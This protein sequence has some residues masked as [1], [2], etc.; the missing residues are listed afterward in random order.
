MEEVQAAVSP[1]SLRHIESIGGARYE[2]TANYV[3]EITFLEL[4]K[5]MLKRDLERERPEP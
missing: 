2:V 5:Q 3:G 1:A 4:L